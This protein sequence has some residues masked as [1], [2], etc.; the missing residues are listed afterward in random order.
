MARVT[1]LGSDSRVPFRS[2]AFH[3]A[4]S[5]LDA[6]LAPLLALRRK[7][8]IAAASL[9]AAGLPVEGA[10][11]TDVRRV[12]TLRRHRRLRHE[13]RRR[14]P[15]AVSV[16]WEG[17]ERLTAARTAG[18]GVLLVTTHGGPRD[19]LPAALLRAGIIPLHVRQAAPPAWTPPSRSAVFDPAAPASERARALVVALRALRLGDVVRITFEGHA[20]RAPSGEHGARLGGLAVPTGGGAAALARLSGSPAFP[21]VASVG[22]FGRVRAAVGPAVEGSASP[23]DAA[24]FEEEFKVRMH[25]AFQRLLEA[26]PA[27]RFE[28]V[29]WAVRIGTWRRP[30]G[31]HV[32]AAPVG[33][34]ADE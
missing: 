17:I 29:R 15:A 11:A 14:G 5:V 26:E 33:A 19:A 20:R 9:E 34:E 4:G 25:D 12:R 7:H 13:L 32:P 23:R 27:A 21:I 24:A 3:A 31:A 2:T 30:R 8:R 10:Y 16:R 6:L 22:F 28:R 18:R 1:E